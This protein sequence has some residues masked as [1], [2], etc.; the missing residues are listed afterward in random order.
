MRL[1]DTTDGVSAKYPPGYGVVRQR[2]LHHAATGIRTEQGFEIRPKSAL[3]WSRWLVEH[4]IPPP[5][6]KERRSG[7]PA[8]AAATA[9]ARRTHRR[10]KEAGRAGARL[11]CAIKVVA[12]CSA[13]PPWR[14]LCR[15]WTLSSC[16][17]A[18]GPMGGCRPVRPPCG[19]A[20]GWSSHER[21]PRGWHTVRF[22]RFPRLCLRD[23]AVRR[24]V[25]LRHRVPGQ[26]RPNGTG[27]P[28][29][30]TAASSRTPGRAH[31]PGR[32]FH[33][34]AHHDFTCFDATVADRSV[35]I[36]LQPDARARTR[37]R[38]ISRGRAVRGRRSRRGRRRSPASGTR[39]SRRPGCTRPGTGSDPPSPS[40]TVVTRAME[41]A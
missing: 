5:S 39:R 26:T 30:G 31:L 4:G 14:H 37:R 6:R 7:I 38:P 25:G 17:P 8:H 41:S 3:P 18:D 21:L 11:T 9:R 16:P 34:A 24:R 1:Q 32:P 19:S 15:A 33:C 29:E 13:S 2:S 22:P 36:V 12:P 35:V 40:R 20:R 28:T 23:P 27:V 10:G